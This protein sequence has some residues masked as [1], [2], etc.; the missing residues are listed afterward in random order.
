MPRRCWITLLG[1]VPM[2]TGCIA[3]RSMP[4]EV[5]R[6]L[7]RPSDEIP[8]EQKNC[9]YTFVFGTLD[10]FDSGHTCGLRD[11]LIHMGFE[12]TYFGQSPHLS[13]FAEKMR[14]IAA[15]CPA[16]RFAIAGYDT[17]AVPA[18][19][20]AVEARKAG[21]AVE[22]LVFLEP[23]AHH[24]GC[25]D[26]P[27]GH[28]ITIRGNDSL[29]GLTPADHGELV[30]AENAHRSS[31]PTHAITIEVM[32]RELCLIAMGVEMPGRLIE[33]KQ[34]L[35]KPFSAPRN[36]PRRVTPLPAEWRFLE[37]YGAWGMNISNAGPSSMTNPETLPPPR[38]AE[39]NLSGT[40]KMK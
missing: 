8:P 38:V 32:E 19:E 15:H 6:P 17:G 2:F 27:A 16:A 30:V 36:T 3:F 39:D 20:L 28:V 31:I 12:K 7:W 40:N 18:A 14:E 23:A 10:P 25:D 35:V 4:P 22:L 34:P 13:Y 21:I 11:H 26:F 37:P 1:L 29:F 5:E 33:P 24:K 9:V